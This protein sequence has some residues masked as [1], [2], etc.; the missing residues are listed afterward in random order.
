MNINI[1]IPSVPSSLIATEEQQLFINYPGTDNICLNSV[2]GSGKTTTII[3]RCK[4][5][6]AQMI[7]AGLRPHKAI[8]ICC[9][10]TDI[11]AE[12]RHKIAL[13]GLS[14]WVDAGT[15][16]SFGNGMLRRRWPSIRPNASKLYDLSDVITKRHRV[17]WA[18][19]KPLIRCVE[20]AKNLGMTIDGIPLDFDRIINDYDIDIPEVVSYAKF[21]ELCV[22]LFDLSIKAVTETNPPDIDFTDQLFIP[23]L[24]NLDTRVKFRYVFIDEAQDTN[25]VRYWIARRIAQPGAQ[26]CVVGDDHQAIYGWTGAGASTL[27]W[28]TSELNATTLSLTYSFRCASSIIAEAQ[29]YV[30]QIKPRPDAPI[31]IVDRINEDQFSQLMP[32]FGPSQVIL[33]R[34]NW[35]LMSIA[36]TLIKRNIRFYIEGKDFGKKL[37]ALADRWG[38][39]TLDKYL[40]ELTDHITKLVTE[41]EQSGND[42]RAQDYRD[43]EQAMRALISQCNTKPN[44]TTDDLTH[45]ISSIFHDTKPG[46][47][48]SCITLST[49]H[50]A[51]GREWPHVILYGRN[52]FQPSPSARTPEALAQEHNLLYVAITRA[53]S[54]LTY[55]N[56]QIK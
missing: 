30:P 51:K 50:K 36:M 18:V 23:P 21:L 24:L 22:D 37:E 56:V 52:A 44:A 8:A 25:L 17:N 6:I 14:E 9:F 43:R 54:H 47:K 19:K 12:I 55:V 27:Q 42:Q 4:F 40:P 13:Y 33:C 29:K 5:L 28:L 45:L 41:A 11:A 49:I 38:Y 39:L 46:D 32:D 15:L 53:I 3:L 1:P 10:N 20:L 16:H 35:P 26:I 7:A 48:P 34:L 2:A 31:G